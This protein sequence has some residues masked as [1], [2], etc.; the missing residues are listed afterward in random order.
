MGVVS[1]LL[2][3]GK[4]PA[5]ALGLLWPYFSGKALGC[6]LLPRGNSGSPC[7]LHSHCR[8]TSLQAGG[9]ESPSSL[10]DLLSLHLSTLLQSLLQSTQPLLARVGLGAIFFLWCWLEYSDCYLKVLCL[11]GLL[12]SWSSGQREQALIRSCFLCSTGISSLL[13]SSVPNL[14]YMR[15]RKNPKNSP[16]SLSLGLKVPSWSVFLYLFY[17]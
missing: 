15:Q 14:R 17:I 12:L 5:S 8:Q 13:E 7:S 10:L 1:L 2:N 9:D 16:L 4:S 11:A 6:H 3:D